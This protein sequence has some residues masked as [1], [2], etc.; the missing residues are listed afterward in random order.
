MAAASHG[1][2]KDGVFLVTGV[3]TPASLALEVAREVAREGGRVVC[4]GLGVT[5]YHAHLSE[6][7]S[8]FL[9]ESFR[10]FQTTVRE[11]LGADTPTLPMDVTL[12]ESIAETARTLRERRLR[13]NGVLHAIAMD[14]TIRGGEVKPLLAVTREEFLDT[15]QISAYS[16]VALCRA[17]LEEGCLRDG[18]SVVA[19]SYIGAARIARHPYKNIGVAKAALERIALELAHELGPARGIRVNVVRFSPYTASRAGGAI[20]GLEEAEA[21]A[22][23]AAPLGNATPRD[24]AREVVHLLQPELRVTGEIR[25]VD[26]GYHTLA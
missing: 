5:P 25:H 4:T 9:E 22:A 12:E 11:A 15:M 7:A 20:G 16:L 26:G 6:R 10:G 21:H 14:R 18:A 1:V 24:L 13:L 17:L 8:A 2:L 19:L 3:T 23:G